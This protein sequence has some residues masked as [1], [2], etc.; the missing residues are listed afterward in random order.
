MGFKFNGVCMVVLFGV[1]L[2]AVKLRVS[3]RQLMN[4]SIVNVATY[5]IF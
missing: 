2:F 1:C 3:L 5:Y 4:N